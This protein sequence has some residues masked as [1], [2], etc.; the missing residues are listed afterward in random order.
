[1]RLL[2]SLWGIRTGC[3]CAERCLVKVAHFDAGEEDGLVVHAVH[4]V[5]SA[6]IRCLPHFLP[7]KL[8]A[9][10][11]DYVTHLSK[12]EL[13]LDFVGLLR[14]VPVERTNVDPEPA[15]LQHII[16]CLQVLHQVVG[17]VDEE[18]GR[19]AVPLFALR[20]EDF[21][22]LARRHREV[23]IIW[24]AHLDQRA[25]IGYLHLSERIRILL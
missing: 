23:V 22:E 15:D 10:L 11:W 8:E 2:V 3:D 5:E 19:D 1:M 14:V 4:G 24:V 16:D 9:E 13:H 18:A 17:R 21:D 25:D 7:S 20:A 12:R 6:G